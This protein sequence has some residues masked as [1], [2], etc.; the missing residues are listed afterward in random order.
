MRA[1][2]FSRGGCNEIGVT[3]ALSIG[4]AYPKMFSNWKAGSSLQMLSCL[5]EA[6][7]E[8]FTEAAV[9][10]KYWRIKSTLT[11]SI[12]FCRT[13]LK[14]NVKAARNLFALKQRKETNAIR[15][16][17]QP[18]HSSVFLS[19]GNVSCHV[20]F[21]LFRPLQPTG[22][23]INIS[24]IYFTECFLRNPWN[25][26]DRSTTVAEQSKE[27]ERYLGWVNVSRSLE[28]LGERSFLLPKWEKEETPVNFWKH[29]CANL[30]NHADTSLAMT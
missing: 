18:H 13:E 15:Q 19:R 7:W 25:A 20:S 4:F 10:Y 2:T 11:A 6:F 12:T 1:Q 3:C 30:I 8:A 27:M 14:Q 5:R 9:G 23:L 17:R 26:I 21:S 29:S 16:V 22:K 28:S 24:W